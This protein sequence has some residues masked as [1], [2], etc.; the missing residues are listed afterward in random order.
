MTE[1]EPRL[2]PPIS[3]SADLQAANDRLLALREASRQSHT[4]ATVVPP[5]PP[6]LEDIL[7]D[8]PG[9]LGWHSAAATTALRQRS[10]LCQRS[11]NHP[12]SSIYADSNHHPDL[13]PHHHLK[14]DHDLSHDDS[15]LHHQNQPHDNSLSHHH[16]PHPHHDLNHD[17]HHHPASFA[18][19]TSK[20]TSKTT[21]TQLPGLSGL[22]G[23]PGDGVIKLHPSL[24]LAMLQAGQSAPGRLWLLLRSLDENG[25]GC[26]PLNEVRAML[27]KKDSPT[28]LCGQRQLRA[29]LQQG[30]GLFWQ[31]DKTRVWLSS[32]VKVAA[33]LGV[34]RLSGRPIA[35]PL[36][37]LLE[38]IGLVRAHL[39]ASFHSSRLGEAGQEAGPIS[40]ESLTAVSGVS[41]RTQHAYEQRAKVR[42][43]RNIA[44]G[45][46]I[47]AAGAVGAT[48]SASLNQK[49]ATTE[50]AAWQ[51]G[52]AMFVLTDSKGIQGKPGQRYLAW[53]LP[54]SYSGPHALMARGRQRHLNHQLVDLRHY[55]DAGNGSF[56]GFSAGCLAKVLLRRRYAANGAM[57]GRCLKRQTN[58]NI[59]W[60]G[61]RGCGM[62]VWFVLSS[63]EKKD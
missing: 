36:T 1:P 4:H 21:L 48:A 63:E 47:G 15:L 51:H 20:T 45:A 52:R 26:L 2:E 18:G 54:N 58:T 34:V 31:R 7:T 8:L 42:V 59:Y 30:N 40:R 33:G 41:R 60:R 39:Y 6:A 27:T 61:R 44:V 55:G 43:Q 11:D 35:L 24:A 16:N 56:G 28:R 9:H 17:R 50:E 13:H 57:A 3:P 14:H 10:D 32:T 62:A 23:L 37:V 29:L 19:M 49:T 22:S 12:E 5:A 38:P 53:Q 46:A 25:R